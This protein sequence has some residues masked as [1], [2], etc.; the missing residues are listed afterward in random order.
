MSEQDMR[1]YFEI[2]H[3]GLTISQLAEAIADH[4]IENDLVNFTLKELLMFG[5]YGYFNYDEYSLKRQYDEYFPE[6]KSDD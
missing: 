6:V 1:P 4:E 3:R 2:I 5:H